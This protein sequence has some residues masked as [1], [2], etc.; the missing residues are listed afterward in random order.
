MT[1]RQGSTVEIHYELFDERGEL[2]ESTREEGPVRYVHGLGEILPG[3]ERALEGAAAGARLEVELEAADAYGDYDPEG[4]VSLPLAEIPTDLPLARGDWI[5][6]HVEP[7]DEEEEGAAEHAH[8]AGDGD[9][10]E[11]EMELR[12]VEIAG[13]EVVLDANHPLA[14]QRVTFRVTVASVA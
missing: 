7:D 12:V 14:G 2:V 10:E 3:L 5:S 11:R 13:D 6:V 4:L 9:D 8:G 1:I